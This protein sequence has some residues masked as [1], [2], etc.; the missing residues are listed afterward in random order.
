MVGKLPKWGGHHRMRETARTSHGGAVK[1]LLSGAL[2]ATVA[3]L[4][5]AGCGNTSQGSSC[6]PGLT[7]TAGSHH[8]Q[9]T[10]CA[11]RVGMSDPAPSLTVKQGATI[12]VKGIGVAY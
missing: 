10:S 6:G 5:A 8:V 2:T 9:L 7:A 4:I 12:K 11:G 3:I 1:V